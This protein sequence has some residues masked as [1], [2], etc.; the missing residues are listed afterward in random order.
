MTRLGEQNLDC[1]VHIETARFIYKL[2]L[3]L[4]GSVQVRWGSV[5]RRFHCTALKLLTVLAELSSC[6]RQAIVILN[7]CWGNRL[8]YASGREL[9]TSD[10]KAGLKTVLSYTRTWC[11]R[12][13]FCFWWWCARCR[14]EKGYMTSFFGNKGQDVHLQVLNLS[15]WLWNCGG[16]LF[17]Y[18]CLL[19]LIVL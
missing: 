8:F 4:K 1:I 18:Y 15:L 12:E 16:E 13:S 17:P 14:R 3:V 19:R 9:G 11:A 10:Y 6:I 5:M 2:A 7:R